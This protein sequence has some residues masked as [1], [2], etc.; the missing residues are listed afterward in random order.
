M[1]REARMK[2]RFIRK[3]RVIYHKSVPEEHFSQQFQNSKPV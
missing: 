1:E 2:K 3:K